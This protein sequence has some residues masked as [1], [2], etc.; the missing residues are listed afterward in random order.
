MDESLSNVHQGYGVCY[1]D[2]QCINDGYH[3][4]KGKDFCCPF[5][6]ICSGSR[7]CLSIG[8]IVGPI[9]AVVALIISC[10]IGCVCY[11]R[12]ISIKEQENKEWQG[13]EESAEEFL[14]PR[15]LQQKLNDASVTVSSKISITF[16]LKP[17]VKKS[18]P[19]AVKS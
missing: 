6:Y 13:T 16:E 7:T 8:T 17:K 14:T 4:C 10:T 3:C 15:T 19:D 2:S 11:R 12:P 1:S 9:V 18:G 5:G